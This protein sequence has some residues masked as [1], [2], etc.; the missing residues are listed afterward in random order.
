MKAREVALGTR[1]SHIS[2][3]LRVNYCCFARRRSCVA[4]SSS[5]HCADLSALDRHRPRHSPLGLD[6]VGGAAVLCLL[7]NTDDFDLAVSARLGADR[8]GNFLLDRNSN[9][10]D[11]GV[12]LSSGNC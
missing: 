3:L 8:L 11:R 7:A 4:R 2:R 6:Q 12:G 9:D 1:F 10:A 5:A